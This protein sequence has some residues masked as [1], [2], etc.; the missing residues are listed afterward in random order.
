MQLQITLAILSII[1]L[2]IIFKFS[3][4][5]ASFTKKI[6]ISLLLAVV[7]VIISLI[8]NSISIGNSFEIF[9]SQNIESIK[10]AAE[11][12]FVFQGLGFLSGIFTKLMRVSV[13]PLVAFSILNLI[14]NQKDDHSSKVFTLGIIGFVIT[15]LVASAISMVV[16]LSVNL[17]SGLDIST[18]AIDDTMTS[19]NTAASTATE[20]TFFELLGSFI[21]TNLVESAAAG[22]VIPVI[23]FVVLFGISLNRAKKRY[24]EEVSVV[25]KFTSAVFEAMNYF[26]RTIINLL[27][28]SLFAMLVNVLLASDFSSISTLITYVGVMLVSII[29]VFV[30]T[31]L[32]VAFT[33]RNPI[34]Y[35]KAIS[36]PLIT[37]FFTSSSSSTL[38]LSIDAL[39]TKVGL[40][41]D[42]A[43]IIPTLGT[44]MGMAAC[45]AIYPTVIAIMSMHATQTT[46]D[47]AS[48]AMV[49]IVVLVASFGMQG[50]PGTAMYAATLVLTTLHL[51]LAVI[52]FVAPI[53]FFIDMFRTMTNVNGALA[54]ATVV[55]KQVH[56]DQ[57]EVSAVE[58]K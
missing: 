49:L 2:L 54:V 55:D 8:V 1:S 10:S 29:I 14:I 56:N 26:V 18:I 34:T 13:L 30:L 27:P 33:G 6:M 23:I 41:Q 24:S 19:L 20:Y 39:Q 25:V 42:S 36:N 50:V 9:N 58:N 22:S 12:S 28:Y 21:P 4:E 40:H 37:A 31:I 47:V 52:V 38:P 43:T 32:V 3:K 45:G 16:S 15:V 53:D 7:S 51:P 17:G 46:I 57:I 11:S 5:K 48:L 44:T 35:L